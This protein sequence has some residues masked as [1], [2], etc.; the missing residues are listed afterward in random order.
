MVNPRFISG[1]EEER[2]VGNAAGFAHPAPDG[3]V[4][5]EVVPPQHR[6]PNEHQPQRQHPRPHK[7][8]DRRREQHRRLRQVSPAVG[9][10]DFLDHHDD[11]QV[12]QQKLY[13]A[14]NLWCERHGEDHPG[15]FR[16]FNNELRTAMRGCGR[17]EAKNTTR[18][19]KKKLRCWVGIKLLDGM[20]D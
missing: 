19:D 11:H 9:V 14:W 16:G 20:M 4:G 17:L 2:A 6:A 7:H 8:H 10:S 15:S 3:S 18:T 12:D 5:P 1:P 13:G